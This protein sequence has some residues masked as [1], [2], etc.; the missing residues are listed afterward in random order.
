MSDV[1]LLSG[2]S[3]LPFDSSVQSPFSSL[4]LVLLLFLSCHFACMALAE[5][6]GDNGSWYV[7]LAAVWL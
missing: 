6:L 1:L 2:I 5:H 3:G 7:Q 4:C